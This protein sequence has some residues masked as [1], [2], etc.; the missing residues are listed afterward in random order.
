MA[1]GTLYVAGG[2][3]S[4]PENYWKFHASCLLSKFIFSA[5]VWPI[6]KSESFVNYKGVDLK[7]K[8][9]RICKCVVK[10]AKTWTRE[11]SRKVANLHEIK[12]FN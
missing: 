9:K 7:F 2:G 10:G 6:L 8:R 3:L 12:L 1:F 5:S 4:S 11:V